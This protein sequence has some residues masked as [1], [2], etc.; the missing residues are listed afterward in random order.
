MPALKESLGFALALFIVIAAQ[1][2]D[3]DA[4]DPWRFQCS[5]NSEMCLEGDRFQDGVQDCN[6]NSDEECLP[7]Q[8]DCLTYSLRYPRCISMQKRFDSRADC[9]MSD[10][11]LQTEPRLPA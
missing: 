3:T 5:D 1:H 9:L 4:C 11:S 2:G 8:F 10:N 6:D 7:W